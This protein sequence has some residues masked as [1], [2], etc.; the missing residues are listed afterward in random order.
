MRFDIRSMA[1]I[2]AILAML[3]AMVGCG[4]DADDDDRL[5]VGASI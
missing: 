1:S 2:A 3:V 4:E 5:S